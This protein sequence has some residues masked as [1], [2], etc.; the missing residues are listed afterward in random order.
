VIKIMR[1]PCSGPQRSISLGCYTQPLASA[2]ANPLHSSV[3]VAIEKNSRDSVI[4]QLLKNL[5]PVSHLKHASQRELYCPQLL[6]VMQ[7]QNRSAIRFTSSIKRR[8]ST[9]KK[10]ERLRGTGKRPVSG[11]RNCSP[12]LPPCD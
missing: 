3:Y 11:L 7:Y 10:H 5:L 12:A 1:E 2:L 8:S 9:C 6:E 4:Q